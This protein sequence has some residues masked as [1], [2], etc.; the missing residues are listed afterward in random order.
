[1]PDSAT[2]C[3][4]T[5]PSMTTSA[6]LM[7]GRGRAGWMSLRAASPVRTSASPARA[8]AS[9]ESGPA[10][11]ARWHGLSVRYDPASSSWKTHLRLWE[12][13]LPASSVTLPRSGTMQGGLCWERV[14][15]ARHTSGTG[16]GFWP[17][18][19][20]TEWKNNGYQ[21]KGRNWWPTLSGAVGTAKTPTWPTMTRSDGMG[22]PGNS[23]RAGGLNLRTAV[24]YSTPK[25]TG[26]DR[27]GRGD[28]LSQIRGYD[29]PHH[30]RFPSPAAR[31]WRS[32]KG[33]TENGHS[34]QLPEVVGGQLNPDWVEWLMGWPIAWTASAPLATA[35]FREWLRQH[36]GS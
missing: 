14:T 24:R 20:A 33:R 18:P 3:C 17:T 30:A 12:E 10:S 31:D 15:S 23:G 8:R 7:V 26:A 32:G 5:S 6:R 25:A 36:G 21:R 34:P 27:G 16:S 29:N 4:P 9:T 35:R 22:G 11:G 28:L 19:R 1:M 13:D 2:E